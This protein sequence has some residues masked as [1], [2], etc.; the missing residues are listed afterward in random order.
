MNENRKFEGREELFEEEEFGR[1]VVFSKNLGDDSRE[2]ASGF[3]NNT[4]F[5]ESYPQ[6][7]G[8]YQLKR[9]LGEDR[10]GRTFLSRQKDIEAEL[11]VKKIHSA[12]VRKFT[13]EDFEAKTRKFHR[14]SI[15]A[16]LVAPELVIP[17]VEVGDVDGHYFYAMDFVD[18]K[19]LARITHS[20]AF[21]NR[22]SAEVVKTVADSIHKLHRAGIFMGNIQPTNII[23]DCQRRPRLQE[24]SLAF[25]DLQ[26]DA[27]NGLDNAFKA[28]ELTSK[29]DITEAAEV[30]SLGATLYN[31]LVGEPPGANIVAP[32]K[33]NPKVAKDLETI[34]L[35]C[36]QPKPA[37]R[38]ESAAALAEDLALFLEYQ[39]IKTSPYGLVA[40]L[41]KGIS[42]LA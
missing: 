31:C 12:F 26:L 40:K 18:G 23:L 32:R 38:Y 35:K 36:L 22:L 24:A 2:T 20:S 19:S 30:W 7:F 3:K 6:S 29:S 1:L 14:D 27:A 37:Q 39:P 9:L 15:E 34:C 11:V 17:V 5:E 41:V 25:S 28:P 8:N 21:S 16:V 13:L 10:L 4:I 42:K 33:R